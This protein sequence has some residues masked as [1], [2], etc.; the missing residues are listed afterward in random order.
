FS[1]GP[2]KAERAPLAEAPA[3]RQNAPLAPI[4][5]TSIPASPIPM[6]S[7]GVR[8]ALTSTQSPPPPAASPFS[9]PNL[10]G[11]RPNPVA[12][13]PQQSY[14]VEPVQPAQPFQFQPAEPP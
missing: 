3:P 2:A 10:P 11:A 6:V 13:G 4:P 8:G 9:A 1:S 5:T 7:P 14:T 12:P